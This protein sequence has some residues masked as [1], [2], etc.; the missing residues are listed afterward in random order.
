[1]IVLIVYLSVQS[2]IIGSW[3]EDLILFIYL[4]MLSEPLKPS[5]KTLED[6]PKTSVP[7]SFFTTVCRKCFRN[8]FKC[9][10]DFYFAVFLVCFYFY[11][12]LLPISNCACTVQCKSIGI[13]KL[14]LSNI[15]K[16]PEA[17]KRLTCL[18]GKQS[19]LALLK[20]TTKSN[21]TLSALQSSCKA[22]ANSNLHASIWFGADVTSEGF[23]F[24]RSVTL[25]MVKWI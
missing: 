10:Y 3:E 2:G 21:C 5:L 14:F 20:N 17:L 9:L 25:K 24:F 7:T 19:N 11:P 4:F 18:P 22:D 15:E 13:L 23:C 16:V 12:K 8:V 1:M 6:I